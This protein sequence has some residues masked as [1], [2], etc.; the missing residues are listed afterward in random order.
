[1]FSP[2]L[3]M[4]YTH[5]GGNVNVDDD[6]PN[7]MEYCDYEIMQPH[8]METTPYRIRF[9]NLVLSSRLHFLATWVALVVLS[10]FHFYPTSRFICN[11][12]SQLQLQFFVE[13][14][15]PQNKPSSP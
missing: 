10:T 12:E 14:S 1:M 15:K 13:K 2:K 5:F 8:C 11:S 7:L 9:R 6:L 3:C 4:N